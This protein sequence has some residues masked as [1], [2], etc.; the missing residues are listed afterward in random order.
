MPERI[1]RT[2]G[3]FACVLFHFAHKAVGEQY[4]RHSLRP[5]IERG[6][7]PWDHSG[8][9]PSREGGSVSATTTVIPGWSEGPDPES[10]DSGF[11]ASHRPGMTTRLLFEIRIGGIRYVR[12]CER[13]EAIQRHQ[14]SKR[15]DCFVASGSS[16]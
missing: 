16:Q 8:G 1:W 5:L 2:C 9:I 4:A 10:R 15:L 11:D 14:E 7:M 6:T 3:D 12:H 13:S